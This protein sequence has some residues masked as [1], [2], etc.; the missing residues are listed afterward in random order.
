MSTVKSHYRDIPQVI[1]EVKALCDGKGGIKTITPSSN[2]CAQSYPCR[3][4]SP[5]II[6]FEGGGTVT[7][8]C[9]SVQMGAIMYYYGINN[10]HFVSYIDDDCKQDIDKMKNQSD[11]EESS[12][13]E[14]SLSGWYQNVNSLIQK[15]IVL[16]GSKTIQSIVPIDGTCKESCPCQGHDGAFITFMD[17]QTLNYT[18]SSVELGCIMYYYNINNDHFLEYVDDQ[19]KKKLD[20]LRSLFT[21]GSYK[22]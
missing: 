12:D 7:Y 3:G 1:S 17:G 22:M 10:K 13:E 18:C 14:S 16:C 8:E 11:C 5:A 15:L 6:L 9:S 4:H 21:T 2:K 19:Q 20:K